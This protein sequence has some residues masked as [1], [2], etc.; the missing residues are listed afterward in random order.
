MTDAREKAAVLALVSRADFEWYRVATAVEE[1]GSAISILDGDWTGFE[2]YPTGPFDDVARR[3]TSD[4]LRRFEELIEAESEAGA[5]L[6][7]VL[8]EEYPANLRQIYNRPP[9]LFVRGRLDDADAKAIAVVGTR[10]ASTEGIDAATRLATALVDSGV[11]VVSGLAKGI[12]AAAHRAT[13]E[14]G[15]RTLAIMGTGIKT[16]YP[17]ANTG[18]AS[19]IVESGGALLS[20]F[21]PDAPPM[22]SSFPMRNVVMSGM[23]IGTAVVEA[24]STSG[25]KMQARLALDHGKRL[26]LLRSL[27]LHEDWAKKY[28][29]HAASTV[30][31]SVEDILPVLNASIDPPQQLALR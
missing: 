9:F 21:W 18:L 20:Q 30:V 6:L 26:F 27:V 8:D 10:K 25:A 14:A 19:D 4:E 12:D 29:T 23:A 31:E 5:V 7:T 13:L 22:R 3:V 2:T 16:I 24:S 28:A 15:G 17:Q 1:R 11:T